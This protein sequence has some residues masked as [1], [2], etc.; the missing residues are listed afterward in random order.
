MEPRK[1]CKQQPMPLH[2]KGKLA[3]MWRPNFQVVESRA[4]SSFARHVFLLRF[5]S[6]FSYFTVAG[7]LAASSEESEQER[8]REGV[9]RKSSFTV[10]RQRLAG[11]V[12][13][14]VAG[15]IRISLSLSLFVLV[16]LSVLFWFLDCRIRISLRCIGCKRPVNRGEVSS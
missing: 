13:G 10:L 6:P 7:F 5:S 11:F 3:C 4:S 16:S 12:G 8:D 9:S 15:R 1:S 14:L 2:C